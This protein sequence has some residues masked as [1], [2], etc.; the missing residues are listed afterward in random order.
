[1]LVKFKILEEV[2][3]I[4]VTG[5]TP[6]TLSIGVGIGSVDLEESE[7][8]ARQALEM[9]QGRGGDQAVVKRGTNYTFY[10][11]KRQLESMQSRVKARLFAKA[12]RQLFE[13]A[14]DVV[15]MGHKNADMDCLGAALGV[16][17]CAKLI[18]SRAF[19]VLDESNE[20]I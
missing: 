1:M 12:L 18:G 16:I 2:R 8:F 14:G 13:N 20:T 5:K 19:L 4:P 15:V 11:G 10:G 9:A 3:A 6:I 7:Q 17:A